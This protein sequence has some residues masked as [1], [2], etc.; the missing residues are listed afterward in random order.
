MREGERTRL[1]TLR[2]EFAKRIQTIL[3]E[4][5]FNGDRDRALPH[6]LNISLPNI[7]S[8]YVALA[9]D[10]RGISVSTKSACREGE[11]SRSH[12]IAALGG[13]AWRA[14]NTLRFSFGIDTTPEDL[15][16]TVAALAEAV[17]QNTKK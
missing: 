3:P 11:E 13:E 8:E 14:S 2:D 16:K 17:R 10:A 15:H 12:V 7:S 5:I 1:K 4:V 6:F 9:L